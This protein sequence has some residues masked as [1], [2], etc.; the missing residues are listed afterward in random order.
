MRQLGKT[1]S[2]HFAI[3]HLDVNFERFT[4]IGVRRFPA[5]KAHLGYGDA[6]QQVSPFSYV[7]RVRE[8]QRRF[9]IGAGFFECGGI[10]RIPASLGLPAC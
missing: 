3:A 6:R 7:Y 10:K 8:R 9:E 1:C 2:H 4:Q 5:S